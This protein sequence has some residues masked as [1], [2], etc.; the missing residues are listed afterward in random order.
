M[1]FSRDPERDKMSLEDEWMN[2]SEFRIKWNL[3]S[4]SIDFKPMYGQKLKTKKLLFVVVL[5]GPKVDS[6]VKKEDLSDKLTYR[7]HINQ[8]CC[9]R[10]PANRDLRT[11]WWGERRQEGAGEETGMDGTGKR[12]E[13]QRGDGEYGPLKDNHCPSTWRITFLSVPYASMWVHIHTGRNKLT[14]EGKLIESSVGL[15]GI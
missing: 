8:F 14:C 11:T 15:T 1:G 4:I 12:W 7:R 13:G 6:R 9:G 5:L 10:E 3:I 2:K